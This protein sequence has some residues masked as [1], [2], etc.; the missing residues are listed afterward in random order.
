MQLFQEEENMSFYEILGLHKEPFSTSP[1]PGFFCHLKEHR[2]VLNRMEIAVRQKRGLIVV[3]GDIGLGKTTLTRKLLQ[4]FADE[5]HYLFYPIL[6]PSFSSEFQF[7]ITLA[8]MFRIKDVR[9]STIEYRQAIQNF[10]F[11][12]GVEEKKTVVLIIDE[13]QKLSPEILE[14]LRVFLNYETNE[15][16]LLQL[17]ILAQMELLP[18]IKK[19]RNLA[20][21]ICFQY[22][23]TPIT[24]EE[25]RQ[26]IEHRLHEAGMNNGEKIFTDEALEKIYFYSKGYLRRIIALAHNSLEKIIMEDKNMVDDLIVSDVVRDFNF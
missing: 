2:Q 17:I 5:P 6:N 10:L 4:N 1:D 11:K 22:M 7:L 26:I 3:V 16:K 14:I 23:L 12:M 18:K 15:F 24:L 9:R 13:G 8:N 21:R 25:T 20:D 19:M